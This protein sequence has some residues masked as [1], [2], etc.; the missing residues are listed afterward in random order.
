MSF[1]LTR[2]LPN[3][4]VR[5]WSKPFSTMREA[6]QAVAYCLADNGLV[7][8]SEASRFASQFQDTVPGTEV[9]HES[10][11]TFTAEHAATLPGARPCPEGCG[12]KVADGRHSTDVGYCYALSQQAKADAGEPLD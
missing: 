12:G 5:E 1:K 7:S 6:A 2:K 3:G 4:M 10:G 8:R 9:L 11:Y